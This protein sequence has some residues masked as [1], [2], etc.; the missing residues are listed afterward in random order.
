[1]RERVEERVGERERELRTQPDF[2][3]MGPEGDD[4]LPELVGDVQLVCVEEEQDSIGALGEPFLQVVQLNILC[5]AIF[6]F[7]SLS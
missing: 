2:F 5:L 7:E 6:E 1:V 3:I 4:G